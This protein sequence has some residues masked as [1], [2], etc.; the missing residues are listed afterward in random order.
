MEAANLSEL[1]IGHSEWEQTVSWDC[2]EIVDEY[3]K[4]EHEK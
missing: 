4:E 2:K 3:N 1:D